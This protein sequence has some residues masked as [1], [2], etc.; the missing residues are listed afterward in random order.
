MIRTLLVPVLASVF[1]VSACGDDGGGANDAMSSADASADATAADAP[2]PDANVTMPTSL[3]DTGLYS[4]FAGGVV[5]SDVQEYEV[6][7]ILWSDGATKRRWIY[8]PPGTQIDTTDMDYWVFP[9]GTKLWKEFTRDGTRI[10]TRLLQKNGTDDWFMMAYAWNA[11]QTEAD[12]VEDGVVDALGT[13]HDVPNTADCNNCHG[14][15]ADSVLGFGAI[16]LS[17]SQ[18]GL[19]ID[20]LISAG[21]L[22]TDPPAGGYTIPGDTTVEPALGYLHANCGGCHHADS[23]LIG[24]IPMRLRM[25]VGDTATDQT[26]AYQTAYCVAP[27]LG[28]GGATSI[29]EGGD[30]SSSAMHYRMNLRSA[31]QMPPIGTED[32]DTAG[33]A[34]IDA[35]INSLP[36]C[37]AP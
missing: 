37:P 18:A 6:K 11:A 33:L 5:S 3:R 12:A 13:N 32:V 4:D 23:P 10:E 7:Y 36:S 2:G 24:A 20:G 29:V 16:Q 21:S 14:K 35:W 1:F 34:I 25:N 9:V 15:L 17:H 28:A 31:Q 26:G 19:T 22:T 30:P 8:L 27:T